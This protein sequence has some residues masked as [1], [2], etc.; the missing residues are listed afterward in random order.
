MRTH[1]I[2]YPIKMSN[3]GDGLSSMFMKIIFI[4]ISHV[5]CQTEKRTKSQCRLIK[6][7]KKKKEKKNTNN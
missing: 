4:L 6:V 1:N 7:K 5:I 2:L 3:G